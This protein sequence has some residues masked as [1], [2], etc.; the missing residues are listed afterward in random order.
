MILYHGTTEI[1]ST[2]DFAKCRLRTDFGRGFYISSK[3]ATARVW[4]IGKA[5]FSG[6]PTIM[7]Y[8]IANSL[9]SDGTMNCLR[10]DSTSVEWLDFIRDNRRIDI[11]GNTSPEPRH[12]FDVVSGPIANDKV[13]DVVDSY[14]KGRID[15]INAIAHTKALP[16]VFQLSL[17]TQKALKYILSVAYSQQDT[18]IWSKWELVH[19]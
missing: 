4:A 5:G 18:R 3:L 1:I 15:A 9:L 11:E 17:H 12:S 13:A 7:R 10:F 2:V 14:C 16:S 8:E 6:I 19:D